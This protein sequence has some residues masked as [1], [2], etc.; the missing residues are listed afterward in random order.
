[1]DRQQIVEVGQGSAPADAEDLGD[2]ALLPGLV[3]AHTHLE[4]SD[5]EAPIGEPGNPL[6]RWIGQVIAAR[7]STTVEAKANAIAQG[8]RESAAAGVSLVGEIATL[9]CEY[10]SQSDDSKSNELPEL[11]TF[12]ETIGLS[13]PR[14][15]E[16]VAAAKRHLDEQPNAAISP[17]APYSTS[18]PLIE[19]CV[20]LARQFRCPLAMHVAESPE[21]RE[22]LCVAGGPFAKTL[23]QL[24]V[25]DGALFP[26]EPE[27]F[28]WLIAKLAK[29]PRALL[30]HGN[31]LQTNEIAT[32]AEHP[33][34]SV[35]YCPRTHAFFG[36]GEHP[37]EQ[38]LQRGVRVA[39][40]TD[41]R[42][43]NPD[44]NLWRE[45]QFLLKHRPDLDPQTV[46]GMGTLEGADALGRTNQGRIQPGGYPHLNRVSTHAK[47]VEGVFRDFAEQSLLRV[48]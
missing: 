14:G 32:I 38:L 34:L 46:L 1:M 35:V 8:L 21:E 26:W 7:A 12:A 48:I 37:V 30:V 2:V 9:P 18:R 45:I 19:Q 15:Q 40:G 6:Y 20:E 41:S 13:L 39:L 25:W 27:P 43:S 36:Y 5:C 29:A 16:R 24:G 22:L 11:V 10:P 47:T 44:L 4:F 31:D 42:A 17:H 28:E 3:N 33:T 23:K